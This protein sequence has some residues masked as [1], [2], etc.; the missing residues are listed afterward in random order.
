MVNSSRL[1][2]QITE[3]DI[4][5][6]H[7]LGPFE[8]DRKRPIVVK[9]VRRHVKNAI[10]KNSKLLKGTVIYINEDLTK[11]NRKVLTA[12][13]KKSMDTVE[14]AWSFNGKLFWKD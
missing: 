2:I 10:M 4:D 1:P 11:L 3:N 7:R 12:I 5:I 13:R 8:S 9:F 14:K 6:S